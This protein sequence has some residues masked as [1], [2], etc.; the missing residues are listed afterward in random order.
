MTTPGVAVAVAV[1][2]RHAV[3]GPSSGDRWVFCVASI[4]A[5]EHLPNPPNKYSA[6][7]SFAHAV[8]ALCLTTDANPRDLIGVD[9]D[10]FA[11]DLSDD[12][13][14]GFT[15]TLDVP[16]ADALAQYVNAIRA[17][18]VEFDAM[19]M[20]GDA[21]ALQWIETRLDL[22]DALGIDDQFGTSDAINYST[23]DGHLSV[24]D[25]KFGVGE[26]VYAPDN[27]QLIL[28]ALGAVLML[29]DKGHDVATVTL[30][31]HQPRLNHRSSVTY[32]CDDILEF[33]MYA[34]LRA[35]R[36]E[37]IRLAGIASAT[38]DD[39]HADAKTCRWC[40]AFARC[41]A[42]GNEVRAAMDVQEIEFAMLTLADASASAYRV[43]HGARNALDNAD[44][45]GAPEAREAAHAANV[46]R[47]LMK[48][49]FVELWT[50]AVRTEALRM[51]HAGARLPDWK[52]VE[53]QRGHRKWSDENLVA[54]VLDAL[55]LDADQIYAPT[56]LRS[57][58]QIDALIRAALVDKPEAFTADDIAEL[59]SLITQKPGAPTLA[60]ITD[61]RPAIE[62]VDLDSLIT[63]MDDE[64]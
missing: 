61:A 41:A 13:A 23:V 26:K 15:F 48:V 60:H 25:L 16:D 54:R 42:A 35:Q 2:P 5:S 10:V 52:L 32:T 14:A 11:D 49:T 28:Y 19:R 33:G 21:P 12:I 1:V 64:P 57:P 9:S 45:P 17:E 47:L 20:P 30:T 51:A 56:A 53:G 50:K 39:W 58:A 27:W 44:D 22:S 40:P 29:M 36:A 34:A 4:A 31:I 55:G 3:Y 37:T 59:H 46:S 8:G 43:T 38:P 62:F 18:F 24:H 7:G 63:P 6:H